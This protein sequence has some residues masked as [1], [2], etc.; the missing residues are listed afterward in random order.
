MSL[1]HRAAIAPVFEAF[2]AA[3]F[4]AQLL[5]HGLG[6]LL[7]VID[8]ER[9]KEGLPPGKVDFDRP[10]A[11]KTIGK[12]FQEVRAV[13]YLTDAERKSIEKGV[14]MRNFLIHAYWASDGSR[15]KAMLT[16]RG[17]EWLVED[18]DRI[19]ETCRKADRLVSKFVDQY[20]AKYGT[21]IGALSEPL[22]QQFETDVNEEP[23]DD[24]L[25]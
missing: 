12:L 2:G 11:P 9:Q 14:K 8:H 10:G 17:R 6:L 20:L 25:H 23:P 3:V 5:E 7:K 4:E 24:V 15:V 21:S 13:E 19:R 1:K 18:L 16:A 22:W